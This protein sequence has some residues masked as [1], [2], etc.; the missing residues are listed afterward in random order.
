MSL[1]NTAIASAT[2]EL[3]EGRLRRLE[4]L[5]NGDSQW[6]GQPTPASRPDS[7][8]D[9]AARRLARL[10]ADLTALSKSKPAVHDILQLCEFYFSNATANVTDF[11]V[12]KTRDSPT[13]STMHP[14]KT[15]PRT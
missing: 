15:S 11:L 4:Y 5:L 2:V 12:V 1:E 7:L 6:T 14:Q 10:E 3:L 13:S 9:T 8:D